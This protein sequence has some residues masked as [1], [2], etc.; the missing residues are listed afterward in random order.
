MNH[1]KHYSSKAIEPIEVI[2]ETINRLDG[3][4][5]PIKAYNVAQSLK[6]ILRA[7]LKEGESVR[8]DLDKA[9]NYLHRGVKGAWIGKKVV[10]IT[11]KSYFE[12]LM[13]KYGLNKA[14]ND[15][16]TSV[17]GLCVYSRSTNY[18]KALTY[19]VNYSD[20]TT[21]TFYK[22][23]ELDKALDEYFN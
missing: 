9:L 14:E 21:R 3:K 20:H 4:I 23:E 12:R 22:L 11:P 16:Y 5:D 18:A 15:F 2:E 7:G 13:S 8:K 19:M 10:S 6:Y 1:D 17:C